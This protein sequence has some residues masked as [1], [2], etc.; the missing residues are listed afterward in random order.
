MRIYVF[1]L[2]WHIDILLLHIITKIYFAI[3][4][5][6]KPVDR[7]YQKNMKKISSLYMAA[8]EIVKNNNFGPHCQLSKEY[9]L[10]CIF[11]NCWVDRSYMFKINTFIDVLFNTKYSSSYLNFLNILITFVF[12][13]IIWRMRTPLQMFV[14]RK[15]VIVWHVEGCWI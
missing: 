2:L 9:T 15:T 5:K 14:G 3:L 7:H 10:W 6:I 8:Q 12:R 11:G 4:R 1:L 13:S